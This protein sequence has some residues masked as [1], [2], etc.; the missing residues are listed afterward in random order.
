MEPAKFTDRDCFGR[1]ANGPART[2]SDV[3]PGKG[4]TQKRGKNQ[5][6]YQ[7]EGGGMT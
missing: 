3:A 2:F 6:E 7:A 1:S 5:E 4:L